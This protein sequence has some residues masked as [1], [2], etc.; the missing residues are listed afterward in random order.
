MIRRQSGRERRRHANLDA[1]DRYLEDMA[2]RGIVRWT[3]KYRN[4]RKVYEA[5]ELGREWAAKVLAD[6]DEDT[7]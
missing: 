5:T 4:G 7:P 3:G 1:G 6:T 2:S